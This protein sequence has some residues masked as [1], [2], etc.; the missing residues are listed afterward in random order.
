M[1]DDL[2]HLA[3]VEDAVWRRLLSAAETRSGPAHLVQL[4][5]TGP[6]GPEARLI[7]LRAADRAASEIKFWTHSNTPKVQHLRAAPRAAGLIWDAAAQM[8]IRLTLHVTIGPG[9]AEVWDKLPDAAR[10]NYLSGPAPG[11]P[12]GA[13]DDML[14]AASDPANF[15]VLTARIERLDVLSLATTPHRRAEITSDHA[16]WIAP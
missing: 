13:P 12:L 11:A 6:N 9:S 14:G 1:T 10:Q 2:T 8:Q 7:V 15:A 3:G 5:T 16:R 4:A